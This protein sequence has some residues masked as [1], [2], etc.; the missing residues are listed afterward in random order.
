VKSSR[1]PREVSHEQ[2][3]DAMNE[4]AFIISLDG[5]LL[6]FN[7]RVVEILGYSRADLMTIGRA[8]IDSCLAQDDVKRFIAETQAGRRP[9][10]ETFLRA[11]DGTVIPVEVG[12]GLVS[13]QGT[14]AVLAT[15]RD[16]SERIRAERALLE[17]TTR[18]QAVLQTV[19]DIIA[20]V[21]AARVY[22]WM[23][24]AGVD[25]FGQG[26]IGRPASYSFDGEQDTYEQVGPLFSGNT[27]IY[28]VESWQQRHD[29]ERRLL[30][31][32]CRALKDQDG[33]VTGALS[34][35]RDITESRR[36]EMMTGA[37]LRLLELANGSTVEA[38]LQ[39]TL[40]ELE[41]LTGS[42]IGFCNF[43][44]LDESVVD[45]AA[46]STRTLGSYCH[47]DRTGLHLYVAQAGVWADCIRERRPVIHN[48]YASLLHKKGVPPGHGGLV[49][50][51]CVPVF[52]DDRI[53][54][55]FAVGNKLSPYTESDLEM[56]SSFADLAW[57]IAARKQAEAAL[58]DSDTRNRRMLDAS[59]DA[60]FLSNPTGRFLDCNQTAI[61]RYGYS[62]DEF[63]QMTYPDLAALDLR[64]Q[65][66]EHV[67]E[68]LDQGETIFEWRH[69]RKD[70]TELPVE[71]RT[72][73][74][75]AHGEP[76]I[77]AT[78]RDL[79]ESRQAEQALRRSEREFRS[80]FTS[81][82]VGIGVADLQ[83]T[84]LACNDAILRPGG[85]APEDVEKIGNV[86]ALYYDP[87]DRDR[88]LALFATQGFVS[89]FETRF[90]RRDGEPYDVW[91]SLTPTT[92][93]GTPGLQAIVEDRTEK[94]RAEEAL[95][96]IST[97]CSG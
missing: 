93:N 81:A 76:R 32:W 88:A 29:G 48:D 45:A 96:M 15:A 6:D 67:R 87:G 90:K 4:A 14:S 9:N 61:D 38:L 58:Q 1:K 75:L 57:D 63:L 36:T 79:T 31:W 95:L 54:A 89:Q 23:N 33:N 65:A 49:R 66:G 41:T 12:A 28:Y 55:V 16:I 72:A 60:V 97:T 50:E 7:E 84:L 30:A 71:I 17:L 80:L 92:F 47:A 5:E 42:C 52:R 70:G 39:A 53:V 22:T 40:D 27:D 56:V 10:L 91:L 3:I 11:K 51:V 64:D 74:F 68:T 19:P 83:G 25:F 18:N 59:P 34:T 82:P 85:Y 35:A 24:Q 69:R 86:A 8:A 26:A 37:R 46:W 77:I 44:N 94:K 2:L 20:E 62:R 13:Y 43:L 21:D 73:P 78:V